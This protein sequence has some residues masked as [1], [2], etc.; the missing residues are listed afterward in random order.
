MW[1]PPWTSPLTEYLAMFQ[2]LIGDARTGTTLTAIVQGVLA[3]GTTVCSQI[4]AHAPA[5]AGPAG[6]QRVRRFVKGT[7]TTR[8]PNLD[9]EHLLERL[10]EHTL[11]RLQAAAPAE[12]W[13]ICDGS[14]LR[15]PYARTLPHLQ[16]VPALDG[17]LVP[18]YQT[19][20]VLAVTPGYR[21]ILYQ[22]LFSSHEPG[23]RSASWEVQQAL[24]T[25]QTALAQAL[26][27]SRITW[28][29]DRG[30]DDVAVWRTLWQAGAHVVCRLY[31]RDRLLERRT[32]PGWVP[33]NV[34]SALEHARPLA[35][36]E[37]TLEVRLRGQRAAKRQPVTVEL[38]A[39]PAR[40]SYE[41]TARHEVPTGQVVQRAVWVV[42]VRIADCDWEPWVLLTDWPVR[43][44]VAALR[45]FQMYRQRWSIEDAFKFTKECVDWEAVQ[46]LDLRGIRM[47]VALAWVAAGFL[48]EMG[49]SLEWEEVRLLGRLGGWEERAERPPGRITLARGL[50]RV[51]DLLAT[52]AILAEYMADHGGLPA[53]I[54]AFLQRGS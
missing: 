54:A 11:A 1:Q 23:F 30:F 50:A 42:E 43:T 28:I 37:T 20:T 49:V 16:K 35:R 52:E 40:L 27:T 26:P 41:P 36:V 3:A 51:L 45:V 7:A 8:S 10:R 46:V 25:V 5:L 6:E 14:E 29:M 4:A 34:A 44:G 2:P 12:V 22:H 53:K 38:R 24:T 47:L 33:G 18:G 19:L 39:C 9:P 13:V 21:G 17:R 32:P 15:K 48:Y 31:Q